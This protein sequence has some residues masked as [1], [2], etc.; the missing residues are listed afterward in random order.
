MSSLSR[1]RSSNEVLQEPVLG[2]AQ[3]NI[4]RNDLVNVARKLMM[5][6]NYSR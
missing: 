1:G 2:P 6:Q 4:F 5:V 3:I